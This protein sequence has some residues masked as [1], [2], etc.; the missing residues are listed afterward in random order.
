[1]ESFLKILINSET[2]RPEVVGWGVGEK[3]TDG[4]DKGRCLLEYS[5]KVGSQDRMKRTLGSPPQVLRSVAASFMG[6]TGLNECMTF[7]LYHLE[8]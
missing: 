7:P 5:R 2:N 4:G 1:M 8:F 6:Y 3:G